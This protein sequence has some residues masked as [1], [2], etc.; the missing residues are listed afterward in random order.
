MKLV[1]GS[2][3][4]DLV[5]YDNLPSATMTSRSFPLRKEPLRAA[6]VVYLPGAASRRVR[7]AII[8]RAKKRRKTRPPFP[9]KFDARFKRKDQIWPPPLL[10]NF[11]GPLWKHLFGGKSMEHVQITKLY[12]FPGVVNNFFLLFYLFFPILL[13]TYL[14]M[15]FSSPLRFS[16]NFPRH[17]F[18]QHSVFFFFFFFFFFELFA[19]FSR[20]FPCAWSRLILAAAL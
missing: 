6:H 14:R 2:S 20:F 18:P 9:S 17:T 7:V 12:A 4:Q 1:L 5:K 19:I 11:P 8:T 15:K 13:L 3:N 16:R 10:L